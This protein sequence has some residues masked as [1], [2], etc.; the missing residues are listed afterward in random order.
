MYSEDDVKRILLNRSKIEMELNICEANCQNCPDSVSPQMRIR[1]GKLRSQL[2]T[3]DSLFLVLSENQE[4]VV[5][6]HILGELDWPQVLNEYGKKWGPETE[7]SVRSMQICQTKALKK[8]A[9]ALN[10]RIDFPLHDME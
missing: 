10:E 5:R 6:R 3:I 8:I 7:K 9:G 1:L 2:K 4:F